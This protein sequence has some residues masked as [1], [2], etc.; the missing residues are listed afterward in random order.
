MESEHHHRACQRRTEHRIP[1]GKIEPPLSRNRI[2][3]S[4][5]FAQ[6]T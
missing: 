5:P 1:H 3:L 4:H 2:V 6:T